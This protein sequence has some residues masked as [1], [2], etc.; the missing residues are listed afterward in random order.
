MIL[1]KSESINKFALLNRSKMSVEFAVTS[2]SLKKS[3]FLSV[4]EDIMI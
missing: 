3:S 4:L 2:L 1:K